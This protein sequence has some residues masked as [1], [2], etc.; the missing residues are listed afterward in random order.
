MMQET[1]ELIPNVHFDFLPLKS[2]ANIIEGNALRIDWESVVPKGKIEP[3][4]WE[5]RRL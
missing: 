4:S 5:I 3:I 1:E 2:Y